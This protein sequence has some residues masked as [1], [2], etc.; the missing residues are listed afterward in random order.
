MN[1][2][3]KSIK[4]LNVP[5]MQLIND[6]IVYR[7]FIFLCHIII[8]FACYIQIHGDLSAGGGFQ[9]GAIIASS[10]IGV[11]LIFYNKE[12]NI[13]TNNRLIILLCLGMFLYI[14]MGFT[15]LF[16][17]NGNFLDYRALFHHSEAHGQHIGIFVIELGVAITVFSAITMIIKLFID[18]LNKVNGIEKS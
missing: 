17:N 8:L 3:H 4:T 14:G 7:P 2:L 5:D 10:A 11:L 1:K 15:T 18:E 12:F 9:A 13:I 16:F 6:T